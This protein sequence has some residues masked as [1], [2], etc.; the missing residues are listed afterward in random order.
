MQTPTAAPQP[1][2]LWIPLPVEEIKIKINT[3]LWGVCRP[4]VTL[5]Q[6]DDAACDILERLLPLAEKLP[7]TD[8]T[9][10]AEETIP[11]EPTGERGGG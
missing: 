3:L 7:A 2:S 10:P 5:E 1:E 11:A 8:R 4:D 6:L 9:Q